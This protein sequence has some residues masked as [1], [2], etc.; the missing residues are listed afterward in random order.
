MNSVTLAAQRVCDWTW[1]CVAKD[2][3]PNTMGY[4]VLAHAFEDVLH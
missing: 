4:G 1:F 2:I 3:H